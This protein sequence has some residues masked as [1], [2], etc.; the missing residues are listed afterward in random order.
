MK[1]DAAVGGDERRC[2]LRVSLRAP[3]SPSSKLQ[4]PRAK[5][6]CKSP[7]GDVKKERKEATRLRASG[8]EWE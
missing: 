8:W 1:A 7:R 2:I 5:T 6:V 3:S 4:R